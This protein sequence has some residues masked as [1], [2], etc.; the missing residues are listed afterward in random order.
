MVFPTITHSVSSEKLVVNKKRKIICQRK[1]PHYL[2]Y[3]WF[4]FPASSL[5]ENV[6][7]LCVICVTTKNISGLNDI[8]TVG[9]RKNCE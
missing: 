9:K 1:L 8:K 6:K 2:T 7:V 4:N 5:K 3:L